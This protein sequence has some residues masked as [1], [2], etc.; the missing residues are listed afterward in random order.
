MLVAI[1]GAGHAGLVTARHLKDCSIEFDLYERRNSIGGVWRDREESLLDK[2]ELSEEEMIALSPIYDNLRTNT[3]MDAMQFDDLE[4]NCGMDIFAPWTEIS[5]YLKT[6]FA[7]FSLQKHILF[8]SEVIKVSRKNGIWKLCSRHL[9][10]GKVIEKDY[11]ALV[12]CTGH[13]EVP[14]I[15]QLEGASL[16]QGLQI[17]SKRYRHPSHYLNQNV[18]IIGLG[19]SGIDIALQI[20]PTVKTVYVSH[21]KKE[22]LKATFPENFVEKPEVKKFTDNSVIFVDESSAKI[23]TVIYCTGYT[24]KCDY[25]DESCGVTIGDQYVRNLYKGMICIEH[26]TLLFCGLYKLFFGIVL[27]EMQAKFAAKLLTGKVSLPSKEKM[28]K[29]TQSWEEKHRQE[30]REERQFFDLESRGREYMLDLARMGSLPDPPAALFEMFETFYEKFKTE[31]AFFRN[32]YY[33]IINGTFVFRQN[34]DV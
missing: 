16:F 3:P 24:F 4:Y 14:F 25:L 6:Y 31:P 17:H 18:L 22:T 21:R 30:G 33:K 10:T 28:Y 23:D 32:Y 20:S 7:K 26:P 13:E 29:Y 9:P 12:I 5:K 1:I 34:E 15:P 11:N 8:Q 27:R 19:P 2:E